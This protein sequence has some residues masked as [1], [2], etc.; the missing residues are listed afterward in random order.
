MFLSID[1]IPS[2]AEGSHIISGPIKI[3]QPE[4]GCLSG[5][6]SSDV[7]YGSGKHGAEISTNNYN[8]EVSE[9]DIDVISAQT[10]EERYPCEITSNHEDCSTSGTNQPEFSKVLQ[11][12][13]C[14]GIGERNKRK[15]WR[16]RHEDLEFIPEVVSG[17]SMQDLA[18]F[19]AHI[20]QNNNRYYLYGELIIDFLLFCRLLINHP[21]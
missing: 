16:G 21:H 15:R 3:N 7:E 1:F 8:M 10:I 6:C 20:C 13:R 4:P 12:N 14:Q 9:T 5:T 17:S 19:P 2:S 11:K 18:L